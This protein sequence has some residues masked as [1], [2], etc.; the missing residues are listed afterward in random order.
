MPTVSTFDAAR[1]VESVE[2]QGTCK[3]FTVMQ[4]FPHALMYVGVVS[5]VCT[6]GV[7]RCRAT[8]GLSFKVADLHQTVSTA[9][10]G[11]SHPGPVVDSTA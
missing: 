5:R 8:L 4:G 3:F 1:L 11:Q 9:R 6:D 10:S 2:S 7:H